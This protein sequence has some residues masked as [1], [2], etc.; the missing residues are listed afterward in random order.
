[1]MAQRDPWVNMLR[2]TLA[3]FSA[4]VG[5]A[6]TVL[7]FPFD[8]AIPGGFPGTAQSFGR[9]I[10]RNM[11][12]LLLEE[13]HVG[14]VLDPAGGSWFVEDLT[15]PLAQ[16]AWQHFQAIESHGGFVEAALT[17]SPARSREI[18][19]QRTDDIA[20]RRIAITGVN[21]YPN[22][23]EPALPQMIR[24]IRR[25]QRGMWRAMRPGSK[26]CETAPTSSWPNRGHARRR[27]CCRWARWPSTTSAR[28]SRR[29]CWLPAASRR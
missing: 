19:A 27:C 4:G 13:S 1:M 6:D 9:R 29:T 20:H 18:A 8:V 15:E 3:A 25:W 2:T 24:W 26:P 17:T 7:V 5:G 11:Q 23:S 16:Q 22:L 21:E 14:R 10:A 12:L 28:R